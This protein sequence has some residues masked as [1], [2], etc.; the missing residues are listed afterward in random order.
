MRCLVAG[1][2]AI[3]SLRAA[4]RDLV[5][6]DTDSGIFGDDGAALTMLLV[7]ALIGLVI[8]VLIPRQSTEAAQRTDPSTAAAR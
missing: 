1:F 2:M 6:F 7:L 4:G 5:L 3:A 8:A